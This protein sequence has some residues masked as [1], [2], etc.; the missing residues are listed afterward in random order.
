MEKEITYIDN[1]ISFSG[2]DVQS[3][4]NTRDTDTE[5]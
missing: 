2:W 1:D 3:I 4:K 5:H